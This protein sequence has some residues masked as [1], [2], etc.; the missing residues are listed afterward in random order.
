MSEYVRAQWE[1]V[2]K[3]HVCIHAFFFRKKKLQSPILYHPWDWYIYPPFTNHPWIGK[4]TN[5]VPMDGISVW[6]A[7]GGRMSWCTWFRKVG[8]PLD[9][10]Y[11]KVGKKRNSYSK[12]ISEMGY[13]S[14]QE[15]ILY[16]DVSN[17]RGFW[18]PHIIHLFIRFSI[19]NH[20]FLGAH[21]YFWSS[22]QK[23]S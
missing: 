17:T 7:F 22:T 9:F 6:K 21:P 5:L 13:V 20:P 2:L 3:T 11:P 8:D 23:S 19:L 10:T 16:M 15:G 18:A 14:S 4:Y 1:K 12:V